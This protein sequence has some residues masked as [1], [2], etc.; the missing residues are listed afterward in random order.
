[1]PPLQRLVGA[2]AAAMLLTGCAGTG[3]LGSIQATQQLRPGMTLAEVQQLLGTP[4][5]TQRLGEFTVWK[6]LLHQHYKGWVPYY[7]A[8][9]GEPP[10][11]RV[12]VAD[13][14]EYLRNQ[15]MWMQALQPMVMPAPNVVDKGRHNCNQRFVEDRIHCLEQEVSR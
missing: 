7:L 9:A 3:G 2:L 14:A 15:A 5:S 13:E 6:Y 8:F 4:G 10:T 12:W 1:M 11:L